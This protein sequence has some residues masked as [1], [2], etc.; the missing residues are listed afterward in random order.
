MGIEVKVYDATTD[1]LIGE[2]DSVANAAYEY[3]VS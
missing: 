1:E 2:F 3:E